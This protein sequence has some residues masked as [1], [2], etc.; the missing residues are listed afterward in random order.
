[1]RSDQKEKLDGAL[2][3]MMRRMGKSSDWT[4]PLSRMTLAVS[5][6]HLARPLVSVCP[7][8]GLLCVPRLLLC[9]CFALCRSV[10]PDVAAVCAACSHDVAIRASLHRLS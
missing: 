1:M 9:C 7:Q 8:R 4:S 3:E 6:G 2:G 10:A 5:H